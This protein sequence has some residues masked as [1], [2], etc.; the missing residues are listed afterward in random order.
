MRTNR[1]GITVSAVAAIASAAFLLPISPAEAIVIPDWPT[2]GHVPVG[3]SGLDVGPGPAPGYEYLYTDTG[4]PTVA[5]AG[6]TTGTVQQKVIVIGPSGAHVTWTATTSEQCTGASSLALYSLIPTQGLIVPPMTATGTDMF[7]TTWRSPVA[8]VSP[9]YAGP[10]TVPFAQT[11]RRYD[12]VI[13]LADYTL[14]TK[15]D[16]ST[17]PKWVQGAWSHTT[18][19]FERQT[20][21]TS[22]V[23]KTSVRKGS[24]V[25]ISG[26]LTYATPGHWAADNGEKVLV[27]VRIG[28]GAWRTKATLIA[29][30]TGKVSYTFRPS[31]TSR[32]RLVH[33]AHLTG[34]CTAAVTSA[35]RTIKVT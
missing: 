4:V 19:Y 24:A 18:S 6:V 22:A 2:A 8:L 21:L 33:A 17:S 3:C 9:D 25:A 11:Q 7:T 27:Q 29:G 12:S 15:T 20:T 28:S 10:V 13:L 5:T 31:K 35:I 30:S 23:S 34:R 32:I 16:V 26:F 1:R 14:L